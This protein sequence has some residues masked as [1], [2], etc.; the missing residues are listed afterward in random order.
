ME[1]IRHLTFNLEV[2]TH[3]V[4]NKTATIQDLMLRIR[5]GGFM[6]KRVK[7]FVSYASRNKDLAVRFL[8]KFR[9]QLAPSKTYE[10]TFWRDTNILVGED[11]HDEIQKALKKSDIGLLLVSPPFLGSP[12]ITKHELPGFLGDR[13]KPVIPVMLQHIDFKRHDLKGLRSKQ[14]FRLDSQRF[15]KPKAYGEC[16]GNQRDRFVERLFTKVELKL[17]SLFRR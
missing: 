7:V 3:P 16:T 4:Y 13:A 12:Y 8:E 14:I 9:D 1:S 6:R 11:W 5:P 10:Y 17:D 2:S 15:K